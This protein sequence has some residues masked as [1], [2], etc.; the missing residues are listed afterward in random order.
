[1][2]QLKFIFTVPADLDRAY[3]LIGS[4]AATALSLDLYIVTV[5]VPG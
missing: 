1:M 2:E 5:Q 4:N 3:I